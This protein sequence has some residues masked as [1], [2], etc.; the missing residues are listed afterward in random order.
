[1][2]FM[3]W[4]AYRR[5]WRAAREF[6]LLYGLDLPAAVT[7]GDGLI[8][9]H[10][11]MGTVIHPDCRIGNDVTI[12]H[13]VTIGRAD[14]HKPRV[15]SPMEAIEI[16]DGAVLCPGAKV[17]GGPGVTRVGAHTIVA[18]NAVLTVSTGD[19]EV[20]GGVP[21]CRLGMRSPASDSPQ[22]T[23]TE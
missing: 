3:E 17:L 18:A 1:M 19:W 8:L 4:L 23:Q 2:G 5:R 22:S 16:G 20:W 10:R 15:L 13:Q 9:Q 11:G 7:I 21:A 6:M 14:A 12:Y